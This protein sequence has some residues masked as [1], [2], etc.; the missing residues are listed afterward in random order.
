MQLNIPVIDEIK[1]HLNHIILYG[2]LYMVIALTY[3][4]MVSKE[5]DMQLDS[6]KNETKKVIF[7]SSSLKIKENKLDSMHLFGLSHTAP[8]K[9]ATSKNIK[10]IGIMYNEKG[11]KVMLRIDDKEYE[12]VKGSKINST[13]VI[14]EIEKHRMIVQSKNGLEVFELF[15]HKSEPASVNVM[16]GSNNE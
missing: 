11:S 15:N 13:Y 6:K 7:P 5:I 8:I 4:F 3:V 9:E 1:Q 14:K 10:L 12:F 2:L 16:N